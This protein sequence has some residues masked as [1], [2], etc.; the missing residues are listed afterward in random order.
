VLLVVEREDRDREAL[1]A[2]GQEGD[3]VV[4]PAPAVTP[5]AADRAKHDHD[6]DRGD[7][8][9]R[10]RQPVEIPVRIFDRELH[11]VLIATCCIR[12]CLHCP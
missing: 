6:R 1:V 5:A 8:P 12:P 3:L 7:D 2:A 11:R 10:R 4:D 9:E